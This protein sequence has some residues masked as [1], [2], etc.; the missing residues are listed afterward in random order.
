[1]LHNIEI[2]HTF[3]NEIFAIFVMFNIP[4]LWKLKLNVL[5]VPVLK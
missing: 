4:Q 3:G 2:C 5:N 1:M